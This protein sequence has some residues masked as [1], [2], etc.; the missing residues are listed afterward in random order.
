[1]ST[2]IDQVASLF[3]EPDSEELAFLCLKVFQHDWLDLFSCKGIYHLKCW[4][5]AETR[6]VMRCMYSLLVHG[7][8]DIKHLKAIYY[9][10]STL[11]IC[12]FYTL[13][14]R[15]LDL[16]GFGGR[17]RFKIFSTLSELF[18]RC[19]NFVFINNVVKQ[20]TIFGVCRK[21]DVWLMEYLERLNQV[22]YKELEHEWL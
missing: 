14:N 19:L 6:M 15:L 8:V 11:N 22:I 20:Y 17:A 1:M 13:I 18:P 12:K 10:Q 2:K 16:N 21:Q 9:N 3:P 4:R 7:V 5:H